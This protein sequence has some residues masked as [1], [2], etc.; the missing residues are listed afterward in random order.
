M[1]GTLI[2]RIC[3][4][5]KKN[6][7]VLFI[8]I[9]MMSVMIILAS[10]VYY[11]V[12]SNTGQ[13][14]MEY[15]GMQGYETAVNMLDL[16]NYALTH[17][18]E[19]TDLYKNLGRLNEGDSVTTTMRVDGSVPGSQM[20]GG[21]GEEVKID[22]IAKPDGII[23]ISATVLYNGKE[24]TATR[25][26]EKVDI[27]SAG[28]FR[29][30]EGINTSEMNSALIYTDIFYDSGGQLLSKGQKT[31][32]YGSIY[33]H[34]NF[35]I[36]APTIGS[37]VEIRTVAGA[38]DRKK[39]YVY[40]DMTIEGINLIIQNGGEI[41]VVGDLTILPGTTFADSIGTA[42][43]PVDLYVFGRFTSNIACPNSLG[44][45]NIYMYD[46]TQFF[47]G[48][49]PNPNDQWPTPIPMIGAG[50]HGSVAN[51]KATMALPIPPAP[52]PN[53]P[54]PVNRDESL[55]LSTYDAFDIVNIVY[56]STKSHTGA[57]PRWLDWVDPM[58]GVTKTGIKTKILAGNDQPQRFSALGVPLDQDHLR[59]EVL[60][61]QII[62]TEGDLYN[63]TGTLDWTAV[64]DVGGFKTVT[65][66]T[67]CAIKN[68][69]SSTENNINHCV[70]IETGDVDEVFG[71]NYDDPAYFGDPTQYDPKDKDNVVI[72]TLGQAGDRFNWIGTTAP[73][74]KLTA[75]L[76]KGVGTVIFEMAPG[77]EYEMKPGG[78][79][80]PSQ[81]IVP[82][83]LAV[84]A[85]VGTS[86]HTVSS[87]QWLTWNPTL[88][89]NAMI[90]YLFALTGYNYNG[91]GGFMH[92]RNDLKG[93]TAASVTA[94]KFFNY[95]G[96][97]QGQLYNEVPNPT[98]AAIPYVLRGNIEG[99]IIFG[100]DN[101]DTGVADPETDGTFHFTDAMLGGFVYAPRANY[102]Y[103]G[104]AG[105]ESGAFFGGMV[106]N[107]F[108]PRNTI[109]Y[110]GIYPNERI[111]SA[112][113]NTSTPDEDSYIWK[114]RLT[115]R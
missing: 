14:V 52:P 63:G 70:I 26:Y 44:S 74:A 31:R 19:Y 9:V 55:A 7:S 23:G 6:G 67:S 20:I 110:I 88:Q 69:I 107:H 62:G 59:E 103:D 109:P 106:V 54:A 17:K 50:T 89:D 3:R 100:S 58:T 90:Q 1:K 64:P 36:A 82:Y 11:T 8:V 108:S 37:G 87:N 53:Q 45:L 91:V 34:D 38:D 102:V 99:N 47:P 76:V 16:F 71:P 18:D 61:A 115:G 40:G 72:I 97:V 5:K 111:L 30:F 33:S 112:F 29:A 66:N 113:P 46:T 48:S 35:D 77:A 10:A 24:I 51:M 56:F 83:N 25:E 79:G 86:P 73:N 13:V 22:I 28:A 65:I 104:S 93:W 95:T 49:W 78:S 15:S 75:I 94:T 39:I 2:D 84:Q 114:A 42:T 21:I 96:G 98:P 68:V 80:L 81:I 32:F 43:A 60:P 41:V 12:S 92:L 4:L 57:P 85:N 101:D 105:N 27:S